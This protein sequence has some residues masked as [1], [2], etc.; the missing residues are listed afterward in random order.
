ML[1]YARP[2]LPVAPLSARGGAQAAWTGR[3]MVLWGGEGV[4]KGPQGLVDGAAYSPASGWRHIAPAPGRGRAG[5]QALYVDGRV[6]TFGGVSSE[7]ISAARE[8]LV[9]AVAADRWT[10]FREPWRVEDAVTNGNSLVLT[11]VDDAGAV[12]LRLVALD[13]SLIDE[14]SALPLPGGA[15][16]GVGS[17][18]LPGGQ[19]VLLATTASGRTTV[20]SG[21]L[22]ATALPASWSSAGVTGGSVTSPVD[23][24]A[25]FRGLAVPLSADA[26]LVASSGRVSVLQPDG[27]RVL[28]SVVASGGS[29]ACGVSGALAWTGSQVLSWG[30]QRCDG[31]AA[32]VSGAGTSW[33]IRP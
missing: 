16:M 14:Q 22:K 19:L 31:G 17:A 20:L 25:G 23:V 24:S 27:G 3:E 13:G 18:V 2:G 8:V 28:A 4:G 12:H 30:G 21:R 11:E 33:V 26:L 7:G 32:S 29:A 5:G 9:Y 15:V 1:S 6:V 10:S